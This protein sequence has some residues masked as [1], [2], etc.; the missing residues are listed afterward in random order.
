MPEAKS[1]FIEKQIHLKL[2]SQFWK[3]IWAYAKG[4][5]Y[6]EVLNM[7]FSGVCIDNIFTHRKITNANISSWHFLP[8]LI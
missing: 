6:K 2:F 1:N 4:I 8:V 7:Y 3:T 5:Q